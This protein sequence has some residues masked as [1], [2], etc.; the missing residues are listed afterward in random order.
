MRDIYFHEAHRVYSVTFSLGSSVQFQFQTP[1]IFS[2]WRFS[3]SQTVHFESFFGRLVLIQSMS[4]DRT[5]TV[6]F[7]P[8]T[9][10]IFS[11]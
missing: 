2:S 10:Y 4:H 5:M 8:L 6:H 11:L 9:H 3:L 7:I 1:G